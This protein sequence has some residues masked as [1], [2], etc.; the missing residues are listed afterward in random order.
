MARKRVSFKDS[1]EYHGRSM[2]TVLDAQAPE[3]S[4]VDAVSAAWPD[5]V[6]AL[7][8][9]GAGFKKHAQEESA[10]E[11]F[12]RALAALRSVF[13]SA[14]EFAE[15]LRTGEA[16]PADADRGHLFHFAARWKEREETEARVDQGKNG[17]KRAM[18][19]VMV[20]HGNKPNSMRTQEQDAKHR[21]DKKR[22]KRKT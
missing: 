14:R 6:A 4:R 18:G 15:G 10:R 20:A 21:E 8:T 7:D 3:G 17:A 9:H 13:G 19:T 11:A 5:I 16:V 1:P 2:A 12:E 22:N